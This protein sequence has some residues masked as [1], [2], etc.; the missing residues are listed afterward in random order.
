LVA[1]LLLLQRRQRITAAE[2]AEELEVS[3][4]TARRDLEALSV[5]GI[6]VYSER[7]RGGG[8]QLIGGARTDLSGLT[9]AETRALFLVTGPSA[10]VTPQL[11]S[12][13]RK[14]V[15]AL[16]ETLQDR[17]EASAASVV[18]DPGGWGQTRRLS[19]PP[20]LEAIQEAVVD[21]KQVRL[22]YMNRAGRRTMRL[23]HPLGTVQKGT[24]W[25]LVASTD[26]GLRTFRVNRVESVEPTGEPAT[27]PEGFDL[28]DTWKQV[29]DRVDELRSPIEVT[30]LVEPQLVD[31]L[32]WIFERRI[33]VGPEHIDGRVLVVVRGQH[34]DALVSQLA[35]FGER[36]EITAPFEAR[37]QLAR[38]GAELSAVYSGQP[39]SSTVDNGSRQDPESTGRS[40]Y[41]LHA[42]EG[43]ASS[44]ELDQ[45]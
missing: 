10:A 11:K 23:V 15:R 24:V 33:E 43:N 32:R 3:E 9:S 40:R 31:V 13:L 20:N 16:P 45:L 7:G 39:P 34:L 26:E 29:V 18:I 2:A 17:A 6:P 42:N 38:L 37:A 36:A 30:A 41:A 12:A 22:G 35:G 27:R 21:S 8:W 28:A 4:R 1:L 14:L 19:V 5:A 25:Y 44:Y